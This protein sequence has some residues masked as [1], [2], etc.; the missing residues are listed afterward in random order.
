MIWV[1]DFHALG[2]GHI[3]MGIPLLDTVLDLIEK[4]LDRLI[5]DKNKQSEFKHEIQTKLIDQNLIQAQI[6]MEEAKHPSVFVSGWRPAVGWICA[7]SLGYHFIVAS[8]LDIWLDVPS[9]ETG[10]L[11]TILG[12]ML[13]LGGLRSL[14]KFKGVARQ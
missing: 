10:P 12:G 13:G 8:I 2:H 7:A 5:P 11:M 14:E 3:D 6:N 9:L 4:P 1:M